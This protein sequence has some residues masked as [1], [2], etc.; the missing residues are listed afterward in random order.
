[1]AR[2]LGLVKFFSARTS[3]RLIFGVLVPFKLTTSV[4]I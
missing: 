4:C 1:M 3:K 2:W